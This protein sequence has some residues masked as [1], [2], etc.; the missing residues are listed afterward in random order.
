MKNN[1]RSKYGL[2]Y[3]QGDF[4]S[5]LTIWYNKVI[6]KSVEDLD[7]CDVTRMIR[8]NILLDVAINRAIELFL[9]NPFNGEMQEGDLLKLLVDHK[10]IVLKNNKVWQL[11]TIINKVENRI[12]EYDWINNSDKI[13]FKKN[14]VILKQTLLNYIQ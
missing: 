9:A 2:K 1:L 11:L 12:E 14:L 5:S 13:Q 6:D 3:Y 4:Q 8:Q 7:I 10:T